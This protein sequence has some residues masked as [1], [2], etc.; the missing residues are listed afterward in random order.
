MQKANQLLSV[1]CKKIVLNFRGAKCVKTRVCIALRKPKKTLP[2]GVFLEDCSSEKAQPSCFLT[3][4]IPIQMCVTQGGFI[5]AWSSRIRKS[6]QSCS[7][8]CMDL[9]MGNYSL[10]RQYVRYMHDIRC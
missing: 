9:G 7:V 4:G 1:G 10:P 3:P 8:S 6:L 2:V 5:M